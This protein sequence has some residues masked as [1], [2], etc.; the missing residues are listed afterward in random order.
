MDL[1]VLSDRNVF[2]VAKYYTPNCTWP[3]P[4]TRV[5]CK[6][7][8]RYICQFINLIAPQIQHW[9]GDGVSTCFRHSWL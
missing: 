3:T 6:A 7:S 1:E 8:L 2:V 9:I 4:I 5:S